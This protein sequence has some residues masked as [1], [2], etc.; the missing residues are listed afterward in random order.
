MRVTQT[1]RK[2]PHCG[3]LVT[4]QDIDRYTAEKKRQ[5]AEVGGIV[6]WAILFIMLFLWF[7]FTRH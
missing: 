5:V 2:C 7:A 6:V 3:T 1:K 4:P